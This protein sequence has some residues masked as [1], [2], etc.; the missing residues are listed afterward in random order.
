MGKM[1]NLKTFW[2][3]TIIFLILFLGIYIFQ[4]NELA[5]GIYYIRK[6]ETRL[7]EISQ[8]HRVIEITFSQDNSFKNINNLVE[9]L[10]FERPTQIIHIQLLDSQIVAR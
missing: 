2:I 7:S 4:M 3:L 8:E 6:H 9:K 10:N 5:K 1:F